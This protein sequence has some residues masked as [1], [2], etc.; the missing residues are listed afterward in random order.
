MTLPNRVQSNVE[1]FTEKLF[2]PDP[3]T[4]VVRAH[5]YIESALVTLIQTY[6]EADVLETNKL[7]F[8]SKVQ[9][10][11]GL[12][13]IEVEEQQVLMRLNRIRNRFVHNLDAQL[14]RKDAR[15]LLKDLPV[16][17]Q[18]EVKD[19]LRRAGADGGT[20]MET[21]AM[22]F[23]VLYTK[24]VALS[25]GLELLRETGL[26]KDEAVRRLREIS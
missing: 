15:N 5:L 19:A 20:N 22:V 14:G 9:L 6:M 25:K 12:G 7:S 1:I 21:I 4:T 8:P 3:L 2:S 13:L 11:I 24:L 26:P 18:A 17:E 10:C 16:R 23:I